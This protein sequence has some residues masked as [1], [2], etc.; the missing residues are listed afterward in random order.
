MNYEIIT[1][2]ARN[3]RVQVSASSRQA[4]MTASREIGSEQ[5]RFESRY[6]KTPIGVMHHCHPTGK[7]LIPWRTV[8]Y[9][10]DHS[11]NAP[12]DLKPCAWSNP[13]H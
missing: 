12:R 3:Q 6:D 5:L 4:M 11:A 2:G 7:V 9:S 10:N 8:H 1:F 13:S